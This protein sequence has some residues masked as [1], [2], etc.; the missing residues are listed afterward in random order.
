[1]PVTIAPASEACQAI[2]DRINAVGAPYTLAATAT[3]AEEYSDDAETLTSMAVDVVPLDEIQLSETLA[4]EDR[5]SHKIGI[6]I[7]KKLTA[8][9][10]TDI[11]ALK[12]IVRQI[13]QWVNDFDSSNG[14]V[15]VWECG[16]EANE[17]PNKD[18]L[19]NN[20][21]FRSRLLLRV[22]VEVP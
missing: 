7:R 13:Y 19:A 18:L 8:I 14:R 21:V 22:E 9:S 15:K 10:Q 17:N 11:N 20:L 2:I 5:T 4:V 12:L 3:Y 16:F 1:M 6:E